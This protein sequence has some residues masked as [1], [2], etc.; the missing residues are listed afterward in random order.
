[1]NDQQSQ[2]WIGQERF[3]MLSHSCNCIGCCKKC[4]RCRTSPW[5][6]EMC[7]Q[8]QQMDAANARVLKRLE[9]ARGQL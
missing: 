9:E 1:M 6:N 7:G 4:G 3:S 5:H 8:W 2:A